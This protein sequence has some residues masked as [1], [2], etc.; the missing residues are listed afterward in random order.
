MFSENRFI[1]T[2]ILLGV[3][4]RK[5]I[6]PS[7]LPP[8]TSCESVMRYLVEKVPSVNLSRVS[9]FK[10]SIVQLSAISSFKILVPT[11]NFRP[12]LNKSLL[13]QEALINQ[14]IPRDESRNKICITQ[15]VKKN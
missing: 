14:F 15:P 11:A 8:E 6:N 12:M 4:P 13:P 5:A 1:N 9:I 10:L 7:R 2:G 3:P